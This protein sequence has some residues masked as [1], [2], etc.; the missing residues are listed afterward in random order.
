[1]AIAKM[2]CNTIRLRS[3]HLIGFSLSTTKKENSVIGCITIK[4]YFCVV[5]LLIS[6]NHT[7]A[8]L[9]LLLLNTDIDHGYIILS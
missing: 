4:D 3:W 5:Q 7:V 6:M 8:K 2:F 9:L 1:M